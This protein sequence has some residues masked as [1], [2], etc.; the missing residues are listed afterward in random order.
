MIDDE[1]VFEDDQYLLPVLEDDALLYSLEDIFTSENVDESIVQESA[2]CGNPEKDAAARV[3]ELE[4]Q[5]RLLREEFADYRRTVD[6][7]LE[8]RWNNT[9]TT[10]AFP[11]MTSAK[12][13]DTEYFESYSYNGAYS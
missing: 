11:R 7:T 9:D 2:S 12:P 13:E 8:N 1:S 5:L 4:E 10:C 3:V 6:R